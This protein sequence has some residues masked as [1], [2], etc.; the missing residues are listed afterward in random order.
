MSSV[1][2]TPIYHI[3]LTTDWIIKS[4]LGSQEQ[5]PRKNKPVQCWGS[6]ALALT[7]SLNTSSFTVSSN[8]IN[9]NKKTRCKALQGYLREQRPFL[10]F[11]LQAVSHESLHS[12]GAVAAHFAQVRGEVTSAHHEDD[13]QQEKQI[14][15]QHSAVASGVHT[16]CIVPTAHAGA[17]KE[18]KLVLLS[19]HLPG[20]CCWCW[21]KATPQ[22]WARTGRYRKRRHLTGSCMGSYPAV[23]S[24]QEPDME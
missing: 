10:S 16:R 7:K 9:T 2:F 13:L 11:L 5:K 1:S 12:F 8:L 19:T 20:L 22:T 15:K 18:T 23:G 17:T 24:P 4:S 6:P 14:K 21:S 3:H